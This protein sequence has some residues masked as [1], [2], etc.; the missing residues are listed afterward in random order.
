MQKLFMHKHLWE[1]DKEPITCCDG[2][3]GKFTGIP[4]PH[5][6]STSYFV[7]PMTVF[8]YF[9]SDISV[10]FHSNHNI[11]YFVEPRG[12]LH[13]SGLYNHYTTRTWCFLTP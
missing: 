7:S 11:E 9:E 3:E 12:K 8:D 6:L 13:P 2:T 5:L 10:I 1:C 4:T